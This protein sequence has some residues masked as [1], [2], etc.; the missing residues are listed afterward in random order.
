MKT[1]NKKRRTRP[2]GFTLIELL[3]VIT[4]IGIL[5]A[6]VGPKLFKHIG[7]SK[8]S[9]ATAQV[10]NLQSAADQYFIMHGKA[11]SSLQDL[12]PEF[13]DADELPQADPWGGNY[14]IESRD[15]GSVRIRCPNLD[16]KKQSSISKVDIDLSK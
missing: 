9:A 14:V 7:T 2:A 15:D 13:F 16:A 3:V 4:I 1:K 12:S 11:I 6:V 8:I 10:K 5:G